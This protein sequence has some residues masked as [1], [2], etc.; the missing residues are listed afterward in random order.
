MRVGGERHDAGEKA[1]NGQNK[2]EMAKTKPKFRI[3]VAQVMTLTDSLPGES[4]ILNRL[5]SQFGH[6][7]AER[8]LSAR[9]INRRSLLID[10]RYP[11]CGHGVGGR[12]WKKVG[13]TDVE[14][15]APALVVAEVDVTVV[16]LDPGVVGVARVEERPPSG[17]VRPRR[18]ERVRR[19][20]DV[21]RAQHRIASDCRGGVTGGPWM[22]GP[23]VDGWVNHARETQQHRC[24]APPSP[25]P[26]ASENHGR[27][28]EHA[29]RR[30]WVGIE[31]R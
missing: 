16:V 22:N 29:M 26:K 20:E 2:R 11:H 18:L 1:G 7:E 13:Q 31:L 24:K 25:P 17:V 5:K 12:E 23:V 6:S 28:V 19:P 3:T 30:A 15:N 9:A 4:V 27:L 10:H 14:V 8:R 21:H